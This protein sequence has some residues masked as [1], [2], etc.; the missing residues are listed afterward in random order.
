MPALRVQIPQVAMDFPL[1]AVTSALQ[2]TRND[3]DAAL[4]MLLAGL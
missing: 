1:A 3:L 4:E 2:R